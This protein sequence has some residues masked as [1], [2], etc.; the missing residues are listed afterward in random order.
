MFGFRINTRREIMTRPITIIGDLA[1]WYS[2]DDSGYYW[3]DGRGWG[4][5]TSRVYRTQSEAM[6]A[7]DRGTVIL[8]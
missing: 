6:L 8:H 7:Y 2:R 3:Q 1:L 4:D 5:K